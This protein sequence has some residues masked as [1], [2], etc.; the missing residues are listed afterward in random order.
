MIHELIVYHSPERSARFFLVGTHLFQA[1]FAAHQAGHLLDAFDRE[2]RLAKRLERDAHEL[3]GIVVC[4]N[5]VG[6]QLSAASTPVNDRPLAAL[7]HPD[8]DRLH[9]T[10]AVGC[11]VTRLNIDMQAAQAVVAMIAVL[12][13]G[14]LRY[15]GAAANLAGK[16]VRTRMGLVVTLFKLLALILSVHIL[17]PESY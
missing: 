6:A 15:D 14:I 1:A 11:T 12:T 8:G 2:R 4:S 5:A 13:S 9:D 10:A 7:T 3:H 17:F 16:A